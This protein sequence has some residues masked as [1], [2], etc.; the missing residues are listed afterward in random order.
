MQLNYPYHFDGKG[1][2]ATCSNNDHIRQMIEQILFTS[3]SERVNR[4]SFGSGVLNLV[5][6]PNSDALAAAANLTVQG[7]LQQHLGGLIQ[8][9]AVNV[10]NE[11]EVLKVTVQ[12]TVRVTQERQVTQFVKE[13]EMV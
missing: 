13:G 8:V 9:E 5:F 4:P 10:S 7:A 11:D 3:P 6:A 12:Y 2:T 1:R